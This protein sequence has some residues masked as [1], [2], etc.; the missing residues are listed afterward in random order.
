MTN[1]DPAADLARPS[2][3]KRVIHAEGRTFTSIRKASRELGITL[4]TVRNR[5]KRKDPGYFIEEVETDEPVVPARKDGRP[6]FFEG[7]R[8]LSM[9]A[10][11]QAGG[12]TVT[13]VKRK[14][15]RGVQ[16]C[17][18]E[19]EGPRVPSNRDIRKPVLID[20]VVYESGAY[21]ARELG[22]SRLTVVSRL[23]SAKFP[24]YSY[25]E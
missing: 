21:A 18:Y 4:V 25:K 3:V 12:V 7:V 8:Y 1:S 15:E 13:N 17:Y 14:I 2:W 6:V 11:A 16:G 10:A 19:D 20:G 23:Q 22:L 24:N 9:S 5:L